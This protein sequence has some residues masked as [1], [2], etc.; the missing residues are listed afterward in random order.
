MPETRPVAMLC[1][2]TSATLR[3]RRTRVGRARRGTGVTAGHCAVPA[4]AHPSRPWKV[5]RAKWR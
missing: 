3:T 5:G 4:G 2:A 1:A